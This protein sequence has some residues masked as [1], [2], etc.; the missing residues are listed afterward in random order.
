MRFMKRGAIALQLI[1]VIGVMHQTATLAQE[2]EYLDTSLPRE[3]A[4]ASYPGE[5]YEVEVPDT[6]DLTDHAHAAINVL[7]RAL[8]PEWDYEQYFLMKIT[9]NP[10]HFEMGH[11]GLLNINAKWLEAL[12][13]LRVMTGSTHNIDVDGKLMGSLIHV[14]GKDGLCYQ[15][16]DG[17]PW[18]FFE[19]FT[20]GIGKPY[21]DIFGEGRQLLA[22]SVWYQHTKDPMWRELG[23]RKMRRLREMVLKKDGTYYFRLS[24]G[25][26]PWDKDPTKGPIVP[27]GDHV[28][29][30]VEQGMTGTPAAYIVGFTPQ[31][32][33][34]WDRL[35]D[36]E[37][38]MDLGGG[39]AR[40]LHIYGKMLDE[41]TGRF[42]ADHFTHVTHSLVSNLAYALAAEDKEMTKWAKRGFDWIVEQA[43]PNQ[44]GI[45]LSDPTDTCFIADIIN[46]GI[47]LSQGGE[48]NY[49]E[50]VDGWV[51]NTF[52]NVQ[53]MQ[54]EVD[55]IN[56]LP[57]EWKDDL[58]VDNRQFK[59]GAERCRGGFLHSLKARDRAIGCCTGN[60]SRTIYYIWNN[61]IESEGDA[62]KV[63]LLMNRASPWADINSY[64][65]FEG[66]VEIAMKQAKE[67][68]SVRIPEWT[69]W[70]Q[71]ACSVNGA[72]RDFTW[73][74]GYINLGGAAAGDRITVE[75]PMRT[76][77]LKTVVKGME[78]LIDT[79]KNEP[80]RHECEVELRGNTI[81]NITPDA[82]LQIVENHEKY[83][84]LEVPTRKVT[85]FVSN[86]SFVW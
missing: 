14:T 66:K 59:D 20:R 72:G 31:G 53:V 2:E 50:E 68:I 43:D 15:P 46:L 51:R 85:R 81:V 74:H 39:L 23:E 67:S 52:V 13:M 29:Y 18:S 5:Y 44:T 22:Y 16:I 48:G 82:G 58:P 28:L 33:A 1:V 30:D 26:T 83:C 12:P 41:D 6:V 24:R 7:T 63:N 65:P 25:Y 55:R 77:V 45:L 42:L 17:R 9:H 86:E 10:P 75:F 62:L 47:M 40:Y 76:R 61:I 34:N 78:D 79:N 80:W 56:A 69:N 8:E 71:V 49:W 54:R 21:A 37:L 70:N 27:L 35:I 3:I 11:G 64:L 84:A 60:A 38:A 4:V 57:Y 19:D 32:C 73:N 36:G